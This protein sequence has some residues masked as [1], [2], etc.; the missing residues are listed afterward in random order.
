MEHLLEKGLYPENMLL[1]IEECRRKIDEDPLVYFPLYKILYDLTLQWDG[2]LYVHG[3][4]LPR[5]EE[6]EAIL[7]RVLGEEDRESRLAEVEKAIRIH[8]RTMWNEDK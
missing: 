5:F 6:L 4:S 2:S 1:I 7:K 3:E 8:Y